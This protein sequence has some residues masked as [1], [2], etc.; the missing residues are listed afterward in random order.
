MGCLQ[1][2]FHILYGVAYGRLQTDLVEF[3]HK[4]VAV[5]SIHD[6]LNAGTQH[7][8]TILLERTVQIEFCTTVQGCL[9]AKSQEDAIR[10]FLLDDF[11]DEMRIN[12]LEI[13]LVGNTFRGL[14]GGN[15]WVDQHAL[16]AL[17]AQGF[18]CLRARVVELTSLTDFQCART[19]YEHLLKILFVHLF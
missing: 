16:D 17:F 9:S 19:E 15:V 18:Q 5:F 14:D 12:R 10:T 8:N 2:I 7:L 6:S 4:T 1:R 3:L 13:H 11:R